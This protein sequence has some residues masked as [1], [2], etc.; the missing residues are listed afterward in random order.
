[1][2]AFAVFGLVACAAIPNIVFDDESDAGE[3]TIDGGVSFY[4]AGVFA[5]L[6][7]RSRF[8][9]QYRVEWRLVVELE[10]RVRSGQRLRGD[11][12]LQRWL[13]I[14]RRRKLEWER[15]R[16]GAVFQQGEQRIGWRRLWVQQW[17][18]LEWKREARAAVSSSSSSSSGSG[19]SGSSSG[20]SGGSGGSTGC[21]TVIPA[22]ADAC[23]MDVPM[24]QEE[25]HAA[26]RR[27]Q[28]MRGARVRCVPNGMGPGMGASAVTCATTLP[29][30]VLSRRSA[31]SRCARPRRSTDSFVPT[32]VP[33]Q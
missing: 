2:V 26:L 30:G 29:E 33:L 11:R 5:I 15:L 19:S 6:G 31:P 13:W 27:M 20:S 16:I 8:E 28:G 12:E 1:M 4:D 17:L 24:R 9:R 21:P 7:R 14:E 25:V 18:E 3:S 22:G 10:Q 23:C 32:I